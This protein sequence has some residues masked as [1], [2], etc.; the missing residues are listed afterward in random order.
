[1]SSQPLFQVQWSRKA[2]DA[3]RH[4]KRMIPT[5][6]NG[7]TLGQAV[8]ALDAR[9]RHEPLTVGEIYR[10]RGVVEE[11]LAVVGFLVIDFA[12]DKARNLVLVRNVAF[13]GNN[14]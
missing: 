7:E 12:V 5:S 10:A 11:Y 8:R 4:M 2:I 1:M 3:L 6:N 13:S 9:L 14:L